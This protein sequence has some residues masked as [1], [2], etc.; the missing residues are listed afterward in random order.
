MAELHLGDALKAF[1]NKS[2]LKN[3]IRAIQIEEVWEQLMGKTI[4][5]YTDKIQ[6]V[7]QTLF[8]KTSVGPLK[9]ELLYQKNAIIDRVNEVMG[10][11][12]ILEV[13]I[14]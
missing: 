3:G 12:V 14:S 10:E 5:K 1:I 2:R 9:Q 8:I 7:N 6:I 11:K 4:A 13:V